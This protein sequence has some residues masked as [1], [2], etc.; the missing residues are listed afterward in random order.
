MVE[1]KM[2]FLSL[3]RPEAPVGHSGCVNAPLLAAEFKASR[4]K[5]RPLTAWNRGS[6]PASYQATIVGAA[7][8][9]IIPGP[10]TL[11]YV[12]KV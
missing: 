9:A 7:S 4:E 1:N 12:L 2:V 10:R 8:E 5:G 11:G 6:L 3:S